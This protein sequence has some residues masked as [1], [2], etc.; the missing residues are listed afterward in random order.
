MDTMLKTYKA[1]LTTQPIKAPLLTAMAGVL[2][3]AAAPSDELLATFTAVLGSL[4]TAYEMVFRPPYETLLPSAVSV[5]A[6]AT[7]TGR[8]VPLAQLLME[9][10]L[11]LQR[12]QAA[13][14]KV[15]AT[16]CSRLLGVHNANYLYS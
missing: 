5:L 9:Y 6:F 13:P 10:V 7:A 14:R 2:G 11:T 12:Q 16:I 8:A 4:T 1:K 3:G 15:F